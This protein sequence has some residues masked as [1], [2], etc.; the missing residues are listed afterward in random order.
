MP[1]NTMNWYRCDVCGRRGAVYPCQLGARRINLCPYC[2]MVFETVRG[3]RCRALR[4]VKARGAKA[5]DAWGEANSL[6]SRVE[7]GLKSSRKSGVGA[8]KGARR[9]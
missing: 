8:R 1:R 6:L 2:I 9:R 3:F 5:S 4:P 7:V